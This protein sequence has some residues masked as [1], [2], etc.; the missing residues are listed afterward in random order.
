ML[1]EE[2]GAG[3]V[4][5]QSIDKDGAMDGYDLDLIRSVSDRVSIPVVALG[6]AGNLSHLKD[7]YLTGRATGLGAGSMFVFHGRK[8]GVLISY[9]EKSERAF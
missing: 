2:K 4:I 3:E 7:A 8:K 5:V 9:P 1:M 6:G